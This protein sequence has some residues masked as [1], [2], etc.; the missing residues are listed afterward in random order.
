[1]DSEVENGNSR[2]V[3]GCVL[4][5]NE[6]AEEPELDLENDRNRMKLLP[7]LHLVCTHCLQNQLG[8]HVK[9]AAIFSCTACQYKVQLP[10][11]GISGLTDFS[12]RPTRNNSNN[13]NVRNEYCEAEIEAG[14]ED[15]HVEKET[16]GKENHNSDDHSNENTSDT[17]SQQYCMTC[18]KLVSFSEVEILHLDHNCVDLAYMYRNKSEYI[19]NLV[20]NLE[21]RVIRNQDKIGYIH[22]TQQHLS[23]IQKELESEIELR[24]ERLCS[25]ILHRKQTLLGELHKTCSAESA[26]YASLQ[27]LLREDSAILQDSRGFAEKLLDMS[28]HNHD[29]LLHIHNS[30]T[31]RLLQLTHQ[32]E[33]DLEIFNIK[34]DIPEAG[35]EESHLE[36]LFGTLMQGTVTCENAEELAS[37]DINLQWPTGLATTRNKDFVVVGKTGAFDSQ[38]QVL[39]Y[40]HSGDLFHK[41]EWQDN[42]VPYSVVSKSDGSLLISDNRGR[43]LHVSATG[44]VTDMWEKMFKGFGRLA[45][46]NSGDILVTSSE[47]KCVYRYNTHG[48]RLATIPAKDMVL[49]QPHYVTTHSTNNIIVSDYKQNIVFAFDS[50]GNL[51]FSY[52]GGADISRKLRC[53][54]SVCCDPF[55]NILVADFTNDCIHL[56]S[57]S[58]QFL[59]YLLTKHN[60][61]SCPNFVFLDGEEHLF[62]GQY[63]G[64]VKVF[65]YLSCV[66]HAWLATAP[67]SELCQTC[68]TCYPHPPA[69]R[70]SNSVL[71]TF[72]FSSSF[73]SRTY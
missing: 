63:G 9:P 38:G 28:S 30:V 20:Q 53:A 52:D 47:E 65:Q 48:E 27:E 21:K 17:D 32:M 61:I 19:L 34:L 59:G 12:I 6:V 72:Q 50:D 3:L 41:E 16:R 44:T 40:K 42:C 69:L 46:T 64:E 43:I 35:K 67:V 71:E 62:V 14:G 10:R 66:K 23:N 2:H 70:C 24:A 13:V 51:L 36:K 18:D 45:L 26:K 25:M 11:A 31:T 54:S 22:E 68:L 5:N 58:G 4:C 33:H 15:V 60:G 49:Q 73:S 7:C 29:Q 39:F 56:V 1:M 57:K 55:D 8:E 37:F